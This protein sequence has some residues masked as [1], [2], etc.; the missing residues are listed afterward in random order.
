MP[1]E[2]APN[3]T[4]DGRHTAEGRRRPRGVEPGHW[5][6]QRWEDAVARTFARV[7]SNRVGRIVVGAIARPVRIVPFPDHNDL[8]AFASSNFNRGGTLRGEPQFYC[9]DIRRTR[10]VVETGR[11][12]PR[13]PRGTGRGASALVEFTPML[14]PRDPFPRLMPRRRTTAFRVWADEVLLHEIFHAMES[15]R[16]VSSCRGIGFGY[17][18]YTEFTSITTTNVYRS[19]FHRPI[20][21][22]HHGFNRRVSPLLNPFQTDPRRVAEL[23]WLAQWR[24]MLPDVFDA[25]AA[26]PASYAPYN[27]CRDARPRILGANGGGPPQAAPRRLAR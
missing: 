18:T 19:H 6:S 26:L 1:G 2:L 23:A 7:M 12:I 16:G 4:M 10:N 22:N 13:A 24:G 11:P 25:I 17:D 15:T 8:N 20:R 14:W 3:V 5:D 27:P 9:S 21:D